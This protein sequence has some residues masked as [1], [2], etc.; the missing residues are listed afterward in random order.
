[1]AKGD[2]IIMPCVVSIR[3]TVM[4]NL[5]H[6]VNHCDVWMAKHTCDTAHDFGSGRTLLQPI[7]EKCFTRRGIGP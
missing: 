6:A 1:M 3:A 2:S 4:L 5:I 7:P